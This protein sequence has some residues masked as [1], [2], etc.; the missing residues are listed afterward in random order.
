MGIKTTRSFRLA[1]EGKNRLESGTRP[2]AHVKASSLHEAASIQMSGNKW[3]LI[4]TKGAELYGRVKT[5]S[6]LGPL[7]DLGLA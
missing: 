6:Q 5:G 3:A 2:L 4:Y 7:R 1:I